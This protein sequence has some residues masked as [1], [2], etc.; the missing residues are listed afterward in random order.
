MLK[1]SNVDLDWTDPYDQ[2][3]GQAGIKLFI[4]AYQTTCLLLFTVLGLGIV[5]YE[6]SGQD[7]Q[8]RGLNNQVSRYFFTYVNLFYVAS[9]IPIS[10]T[11]TIYDGN[12]DIF[13]DLHTLEHL[14]NAMWSTNRS[15]QFSRGLS[16]IPDNVPYR[17]CHCRILLDEVSG[18]CRVQAD[19]PNHGR[20]S[21]Q[22]F[23]SE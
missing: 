9:D 13:M 22:V 11:V 21:C 12:P 16:G 10:D 6:R 1:I 14:E 3:D 18:C 15:G 7:P 2:L 4:V 8:K 23:A 17:F 19:A 5:S 20:L